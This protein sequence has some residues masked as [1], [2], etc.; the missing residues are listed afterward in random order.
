MGGV[1]MVFRMS[2]K[3]AKS[4]KMRLFPILLVLLAFGT[5][6]EQTRPAA[7]HVPSAQARSSMVSRPPLEPVQLIFEASGMKSSNPVLVLEYDDAGVPV[8]VALEPA[9]GNESLDQAILEWGRQVRM[10]PGKAGTKRLPFDLIDGAAEKSENPSDIHFPEIAVTDLVRVPPMQPIGQAMSRQKIHFASVQ[11]LIEYDASGKVF[12]AR[13]EQ[14]TG[15][16]SL[17]SAFIDWAK[18]LK[19]KSGESGKGRFPLE[20]N[21]KPATAVDA[22]SNRL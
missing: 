14:S 13:L 10:A 21:G 2:F 3:A 12:S 20:I 18:R 17:D 11:L 6:A 9:S 4:V 16:D 1:D 5:F 22:A 15:N 7:S 19:I 8:N